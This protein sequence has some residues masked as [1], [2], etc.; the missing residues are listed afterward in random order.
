MMS[1]PVTISDFVTPKLQAVARQL[2]HPRLLLQA[3]GRRV[4]QVLQGHFLRRD[5]QPNKAGVWKSHWW[6]REVK[7]NTAYQGA[8]DTEATVSI[9]S[10]QFLQRLKGGRIS[11]N[12]FLA[13]PLTE[14]AKRKGS[15][16][17]WTSKG[18]G[19]L[20]FLRSKQRVAYL[21]P[22]EGETHD[23]SYLLVRSVNQQPDPE[24]LPPRGDMEAGAE[25]ETERFVR[26]M[27]NR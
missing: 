6:N 20:V 25:D 5:A 4:E 21:F 22:G 13:L 7:R 14:Q 10:R 2:Q 11:G 16:G 23:A 18:D 9:A 19:K 17:E 3:V 12:P 24:A 15:P 1:E 27:I 26:R 8:T